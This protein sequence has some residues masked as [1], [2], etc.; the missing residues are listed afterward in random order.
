MRLIA[1]SL[2]E[3]FDPETDPVRDMHIGGVDLQQMF[4]DT[5]GKGITEW[6]QR[7]HDLDLLNKKVTFTDLDSGKEITTVLDNIKRGQLPNEI[8]FYPKDQVKHRVD[9]KSK[10]YIH[11]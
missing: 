5:V 4:K 1:E 7:W 8:Y 9:I 3:K 10:L 6:W 11:E 2:Y